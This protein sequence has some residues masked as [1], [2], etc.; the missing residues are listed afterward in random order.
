MALPTLLELVND[1]LIRLREP[2]VTDINDNT[3]SKLVAKFIN[4]SK[5]QVE[6]AYNWNAL[7][8]TVV[9]TT[10]NGTETYSLT[11]ANG[12]FKVINV[13]NSTTREFLAPVSKTQM[14][15]NLLANASPAT[16]S[17]SEYNVNGVDTNGI[18]KVTFYPVP[19]NTYSVLFNLFDPEDDMVNNTD[20]MRVPKDPVVHLAYAKATAERGEDGGVQS[21]EAYLLYLQ[22]LG[23]MIAIEQA[24]NPE[25][26]Q[27]NPI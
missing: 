24:R 15:I 18:P 4:D 22:V 21:S 26:D 3:I 16:G 19:D 23:D 6:D 14:T 1:V 13:F 11:G 7:S 27:W 8:N 12:R 25:E 20:T 9:T 10:A 2:E 5:R 17:P